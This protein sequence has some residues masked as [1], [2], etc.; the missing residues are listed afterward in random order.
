MQITTTLLDGN[1][2]DLVS[3]NLPPTSLMC[4]MSS[5][6][7]VGGNLASPPNASQLLP[8]RTPPPSLPIPTPKSPYI[9][10]GGVHDYNGLQCP[11][12]T[13]PHINKLI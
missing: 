13:I 11:Y 9:L 8:T 5:L 12:V 4:S 7:V 2:M 6:Q 3:L 10:V 1:V